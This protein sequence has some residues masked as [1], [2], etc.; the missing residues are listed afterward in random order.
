MVRD[1]RDRRAASDKD[2]A[3]DPAFSVR[4]G[5]PSP[6]TA[7][8]AAVAAVAAAAAKSRSAAAYPVLTLQTS[9]RKIP[10]ARR[11]HRSRALGAYLPCYSIKI[12][13]SERLGG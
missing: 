10:L 6:E 4:I 1:G 9:V 8:A 11:A 13:S 5:D 3:S 2:A 7:V 12:F